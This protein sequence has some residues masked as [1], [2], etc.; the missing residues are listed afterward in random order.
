MPPTPEPVDHRRV[1]VG[2]DERV[3]E[4]D[5]V[6]HGDHLTE[7]LEVH[8]VAD[9]G[10]GRHDA[11]PLERLL[12]PPKEGVPLAVPPILELDVALVRLGRAEEVDLHG[13]VDHEVD[14]DRGL[15]RHRVGAGALRG[16]AH[17]GEVDDG[18]DA[19]EVLHQHASWHERDVVGGAGPPG[20]RSDVVFGDVAGA[21]A[22]QQVLEEDQDGLREPREVGIEPIQ[23][24]E[25]DVAVGGL[26]PL[27]SIGEVA[28]HRCI[29]PSA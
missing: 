15:D 13:V 14:R 4:R 7:V 22:P 10:A 16:A 12:R 11:E 27:S 8:L 25:I 28:A 17:R 29:S 23:P 9:A 21:A 3:G 20:E 5:A 24:E 19:G 6:P 18:R 2:A 1:G 26:Q